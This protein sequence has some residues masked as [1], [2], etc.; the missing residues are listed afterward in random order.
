MVELFSAIRKNTEVTAKW[1]AL[2]RE[3]KDRWVRELLDYCLV[4]ND[5]VDVLEK[6]FDMAALWAEYE[7]THRYFGSTH[8]ILHLRSV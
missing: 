5:L 2:K 3:G 4:R 8:R 7:K 1:N 6:F